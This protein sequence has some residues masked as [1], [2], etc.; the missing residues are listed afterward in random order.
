MNA[1]AARQGR[2]RSALTLLDSRAAFA[3]LVLLSAIPLLGPDVSPL[4]DVPGHMARYRVMLGTDAATLGQYYSF[5]WKP[6]GY[7][8]FELL[9]S[10]IAPITG[11]EPAVKLLTIAIPMIAVAGILNLSRVAHGSVQPSALFAVPLVYHLTFLYGFL[12]YTMAMALMLNALALWLWL[13]KRD[14]LR[15]RALLFVPI[16]VSIW[17]FHVIGW[18]A[19]GLV[20]FMAEWASRRERGEPHFRAILWAAVS[21]LPMCLPMLAFLNWSPAGGGAA[22]GIWMSLRAKPLWLLTV[23]R[24]RWIMFDLASVAVL[25]VMLYYGWRSPVQR[26]SRPLLAAVAGLFALFLVMPFQQAFADARLAPYL[27][28]LALVA[29]GPAKADRPVSNNFLLYAGLAFV[30]V[31]MVGAAISISIE[32]DSWKQRLVALDHL[33]YGSRVVAFSTFPC[34]Q[35]WRM[36]RSGHIAGM[37]VV[38]RGSFSNDQYNLGPSALLTVKERGLGRFAL[39]PSQAVADRHCGAM[40]GDPTLGESLAEFPRD[41]F[42]YVW[43][44]DPQLRPGMARGLQPVW[45]DG[46]DMVLKIDHDRGS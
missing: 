15:L 30:L 32:W 4:V 41:K 37:A 18:M 44:I 24:D 9:V 19:L 39:D 45:S 17:L 29:I 36:R 21:C 22:D 33:P 14:Q 12:N 20:I 1:G 27:F 38:R 2:P 31:R 6:I 23:L 43:L 16:S 28:I 10:L 40:I 26:Y 11:L 34:E 42:D 13:G 8:G 25:L 35:G 7:I 46:R 3:L 5:E